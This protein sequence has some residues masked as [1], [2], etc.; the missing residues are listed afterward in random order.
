MRKY[1]TF[2]AS[3]FSYL[4]WFSI[5]FSI[6]WFILGA[7]IN[8]FLIASMIYA[9]SISVALSPVGE[10]LLRLIENCRHPSTEQEKAYLLPI[11]EEVYVQAKVADSH[12]SKDVQIFIIDSIYPNAFAIGRKTVAV[13]RGAMEG[14][15]EEELK[16][17]IAHELGH[18]TYGHT[19]ARLLLI[20][21][22]I[23]FYIIVWVLRMLLYIVE[24]ITSA[25]AYVNVVGLVFRFMAFVVRI[26]FEATMFFKDSYFHL[27]NI[28]TGVRYCLR[29]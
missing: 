9:T 10:I 7:N 23:F 16:G 19:K 26:V 22:N 18:L 14:F 4:L 27:Q 28:F 1:L 21:G 15:T 8:G 3:N 13:T 11:F 5:Y 6:A 20:I 2:F 24:T 29:P 12:L 17:V 25:L